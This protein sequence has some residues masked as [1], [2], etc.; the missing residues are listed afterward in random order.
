MEKCVKIFPWLYYH[1]VDKGYKSRTCCELF[2]AVDSKGGHAQDELSKVPVKSLTEQPQRYLRG[3]ESSNKH[4]KTT[5]E[6]GCQILLYVRK[7]VLKQR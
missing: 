2:L 4:I 5:S 7:I 1:S 6:L 3:H